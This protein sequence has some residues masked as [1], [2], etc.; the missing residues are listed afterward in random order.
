[1]KFYMTKGLLSLV[2][3]VTTPLKAE[4]S[5]LDVFVESCR[6]S[7]E[8]L[9]LIQT[10]YAEFDCTQ[11]QQ[12]PSETIQ[13]YVEMFESSIKAD[14]GRYTD[15]EIKTR[16]ES[17]QNMSRVMAGK[18]HFKCRFKLLFVGND[19][20][21]APNADVCKRR[22]SR[23][24]YDTN[25]WRLGDFVIME[26]S[27]NRGGTSANF[28]SGAMEATVENKI[29]M[30]HEFQRF[31]RMHKSE[32]YY[33]MLMCMELQ[34]R[35]KFQIS[36]GAIQEFKGKMKE[37]NYSFEMAGTASYDDSETATIV[38]VKSGSQVLERFWIDTSRE[39]I[40]PLIQCF[41]ERGKIEKECKSS[42]YFFHE[43]SGLWYPEN[44]EETLSLPFPMKS[45]YVL[46]RETFRLNHAVSD[47]MFA[48]DI[49]PLTSFFSKSQI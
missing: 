20:F 10:G 18:E 15:D 9:N 17:I 36:E 16:L 40:C 41:D 35:K 4:Y 46:N 11:N 2:F 33:T 44:Y 14:E 12:I 19:V 8:N 37:K 49:S 32:S 31:G 3:F 29:I 39:Y 1:M 30:G 43:E 26:G 27:P 5:A 21:F 25:Q 28:I 42:N 7:G 47:N 45:V 38:E 23:E 22:S 48:I 34:D 24:Q 6:N 13:M